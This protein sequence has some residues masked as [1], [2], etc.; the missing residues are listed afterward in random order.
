M[1]PR[2]DEVL[3]LVSPPGVVAMRELVQLQVQAAMVR[4]YAP[5]SPDLSKRL[6]QVLAAVSDADLGT[7]VIRLEPV[8][9]PV[10]AFFLT[11]GDLRRR[12]IAAWV[13]RGMLPD[14]TPDIL[15]ISFAP[16]DETPH[17]PEKG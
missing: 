7:F 8:F 3:R 15:T 4:G 11:E 2:L 5:A 10:K 17:E 16:K 9:A 14:Q 6:Q 1:D 12:T 13:Y